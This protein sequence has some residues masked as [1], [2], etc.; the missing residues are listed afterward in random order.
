MREAEEVKKVVFLLV[1]LIPY[2]EEMIMNDAT[3]AHDHDI[4]DDPGNG[5][6][7]R[8]RPAMIDA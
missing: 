5:R 3:C 8:Y 4:L 7:P 6:R 1:Y 2:P